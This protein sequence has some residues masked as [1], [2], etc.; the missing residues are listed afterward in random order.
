MRKFAI[1]DIHGC[2]KTLRT[3]LER[4][5]EITP[6]DELYLLGDLVD[7]GPDSKG[8]IDYI[9][10]LKEAGYQVNCLK[11]N[12]EEM[13]VQAARNSRETAMWLYNGGKETLQSF[14]I[15][16][17]GQI[18]DKYLDFVDS[19]PFFY[20]VD[21]Y[22]L[23]HAG[24]N[25]I[26]E[27]SNGKKEKAGFLWNMHNPLKDLDAMMWIRWWY[28]DID[29]SWLKDRVIIHGHTPMEAD[30]IWDMLDVLEEDQV[31]DID[32]GCFAKY[33]DGLGKLAAF[34]MTNRELH[35]QENLDM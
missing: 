29:W 25:F 24:L 21:E 27:E 17:P 18:S 12:H 26:P 16:D 7:R 10:Q 8:V 32:N 35:F 30:E 20:E 2:N 5:L 22:I 14:N 33:M 9:I 19:L 28:E 3:L 34:D 6:K 23:V 4:R 31:L 15:E 13:M 11:G 1:S